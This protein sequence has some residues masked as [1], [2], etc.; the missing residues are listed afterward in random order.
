[1]RSLH[2][3]RISV[4]T[5]TYELAEP[6][7]HCIADVLFSWPGSAEYYTE[8]ILKLMS[9]NRESREGMFKFSWVSESRRLVMTQSDTSVTRVR[10][11]FTRYS[12]QH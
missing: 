11:M 3:N 6:V 7:T 2:V 10:A 5:M 9:E 4:Q 1:M 8:R 12:K